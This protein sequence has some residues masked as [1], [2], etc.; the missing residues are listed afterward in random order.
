MTDTEHP[1]ERDSDDAAAAV[2][3]KAHEAKTETERAADRAKDD[4][5]SVGHKISDAIEDVIPG[6]SDRDGH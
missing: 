4:V 3:E 6:D 5:S 1:I 2:R